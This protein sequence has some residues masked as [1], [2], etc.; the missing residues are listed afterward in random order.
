MSVRYIKAY[1]KIY[2][3]IDLTNY[4]MF[5]L[6][7][8]KYLPRGLVRDDSPLWGSSYLGPMCKRENLHIRGFPNNVIYR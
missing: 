1:A 7:L 2:T 5:K 4:R 6:N 3:R 8:H